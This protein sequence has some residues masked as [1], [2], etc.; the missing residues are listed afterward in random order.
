MLDSLQ[1]TW[2]TLIPPFLAGLNIFFE[3]KGLLGI[4]LGTHDNFSKVLP[5]DH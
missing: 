1:S 4:E 2:L 3:K 5:L